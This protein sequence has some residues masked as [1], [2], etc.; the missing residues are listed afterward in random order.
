MSVRL[1]DAPRQWYLRVKK[2]LIQLGALFSHSLK[3]EIQRIICL[4]MDDFLW[5]GTNKFK[6][7]VANKLQD[8]FL[9]G[10]RESKVFKYVG[11]NIRK[12]KW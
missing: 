7:N 5:A 8:L 6:Q 12:R 9:I 3:S 10:S 11:L 1:C 4:Y 2:E